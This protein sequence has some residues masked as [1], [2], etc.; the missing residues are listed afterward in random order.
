L[1]DELET[2]VKAGLS[3]ARVLRMATADA[4]R[5]LGESDRSGT[6]AVGRRADLVLLDA[7]PLADIANTRRVRAV[8]NNG[9]LFRRED[10]DA[11]VSTLPKPKRDK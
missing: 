10:L 1:A 7:D 4:A 3:P 6:I 2:L 8:V 9:R 5:F 11:L